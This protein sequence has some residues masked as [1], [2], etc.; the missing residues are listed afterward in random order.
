MLDILNGDIRGQLILLVL[1]E[2][3]TVLLEPV[4]GAILHQMEDSFAR[5]ILR[6]PVDV[7]L[8]PGHCKV[9]TDHA[10]D[11][12]PVV[13]RHDLHR[14]DLCHYIDLLEEGDRSLSVF[15]IHFSTRRYQ[16]NS[17]DIMPQAHLLLRQRVQ[18]CISS[19]IVPDIEHLINV[20]IVL[21]K[22]VIII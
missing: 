5:E 10:P 2:E 20:M 1:C 19:L 4:L 6:S 22:E 17:S 12:V 16:D 13:A 8:A 3:W 7:L 9:R 18:H 14:Q 15:N 21:V 11:F